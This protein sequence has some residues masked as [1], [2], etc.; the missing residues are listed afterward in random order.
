MYPDKATVIQCYL[1]ITHATW[2]DKYIDTQK[3]QQSF[4]AIKPI[5]RCFFEK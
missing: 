1:T 3:K 2:K 5:T 4:H